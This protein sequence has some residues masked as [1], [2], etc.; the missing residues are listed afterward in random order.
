MTALSITWAWWHRGSGLEGTASRWLPG[1]GGDGRYTKKSRWKKR[2]RRKLR[3]V[4]LSDF[5]DQG[6]GL[7]A[8]WRW[9]TSEGCVG[10]LCCYCCMPISSAPQAAGCGRKDERE[11]LNLLSSIMLLQALLAWLAYYKQSMEREDGGFF[12]LK[13]FR[14]LLMWTRT[15]CFLLL[16]C[17]EY[18]AH[19]FKYLNFLQ[20]KIHCME[21]LGV[22]LAVARD[23]FFNNKKQQYLR[24]TAMGT[25]SNT[26]KCIRHCR[27]VQ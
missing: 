8:C 7:C 12:T 11:P 9:S 1:G 3:C 20:L 27:F 14:R 25:A 23:F 18:F 16:G 24:L 26:F 4:C 17:P 10:T 5:W 2:K 21:S 19:T 13:Y 15:G 22:L 6:D